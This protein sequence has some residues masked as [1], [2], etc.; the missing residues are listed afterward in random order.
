MRHRKR[1]TGGSLVTSHAIK[2]GITCDIACEKLGVWHASHAMVFITCDICH[3]PGFLGASLACDF[4]PNPIFYR[5]RPPGLSRVMSHATI[6]PF[7]FVVTCDDFFLYFL[8]VPASY[9]ISHINNNKNI[10]LCN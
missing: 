5:M 10:F 3:T 8:S 2:T 9:V 6:L 4:A 7:F 1:K